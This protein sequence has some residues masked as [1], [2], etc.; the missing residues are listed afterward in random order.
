MPMPPELISR[1]TRNLPLT[2]IGSAA[3]T[4]G[5]RQEQ[6]AT[7]PGHIVPHSGH[8]APG[9]LSQLTAARRRRLGAIAVV[10]RELPQPAVLELDRR[11]AADRPDEAGDPVCRTATRPRVSP[12]AI[13][14]RRR[15]A[16]STSGHSSVNPS[17]ASHARSA[18]RQQARHRAVGL[19]VQLDVAANQTQE[20]HEHRLR[21]QRPARPFERD[22]LVCVLVDQEHRDRRRMDGAVDLAREQ[23]GDLADAPGVAEPVL[24]PRER[25]RV[26]DGAAKKPAV[27][28]LQQPLAKHQDGE[29]GQGEAEQSGRLTANLELRAHAGAVQVHVRAPGRSTARRWRSRR[30]TWRGHAGSSCAG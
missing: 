29:A 23:P 21:A 25:F 6:I 20:L 22:E 11:A 9:S 4:V 3:G 17:S 19:G 30:R 15:S 8:W 24:D 27:D 7:L 12:S 14:P 5:V 18:L 13:M 26:V 28:G 1:S 2:R 10:G 16:E